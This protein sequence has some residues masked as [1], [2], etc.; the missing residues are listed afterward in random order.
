[1][2]QKNSRTEEETRKKTT[3]FC[4]CNRGMSLELRFL[5][6]KKYAMTTQRTEMMKLECQ[7]KPG[8]D[9]MTLKDR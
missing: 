8:S 3:E 5:R 7:M 4:G 6:E 1:M 9:K 2:I